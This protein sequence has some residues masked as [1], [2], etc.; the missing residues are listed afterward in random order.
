[1]RS[2]IYTL[3]RYWGAD[4][5]DYAGLSQFSVSLRSYGMRGRYAANMSKT[6]IR[7]SIY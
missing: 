2:S 7:S 1:M 4:I 3:A 6:R 5:L